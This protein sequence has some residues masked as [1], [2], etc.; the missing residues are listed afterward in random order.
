[1]KRFAALY[2]RLD[3]TTKT[4]RKVEAMRDYF[5]AVEPADAAWAVCF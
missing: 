4:N 5:A 3:E 2:A 1:M